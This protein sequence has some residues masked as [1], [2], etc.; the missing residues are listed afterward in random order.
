[1]PR[2]SDVLFEFYRFLIP[3]SSWGGVLYQDTVLGMRIDREIH[4]P[5][6]LHVI[7]IGIPTLVEKS[8][9]FFF[10]HSI[11]L[12]LFPCSSISMVTRRKLS[13]LGKER[14]AEHHHLMYIHSSSSSYKFLNLISRYRSEKSWQQFK[15][16]QWKRL[17][18]KGTEREGFQWIFQMSSSSW[19]FSKV[20]SLLMPPKTIIT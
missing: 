16:T 15:T 4:T 12:S 17:P 19:T 11:S 18:R 6:H 5:V 7:C 14:F 20:V 2:M 13:L 3:F 9:T 10:T 8:I 1:M